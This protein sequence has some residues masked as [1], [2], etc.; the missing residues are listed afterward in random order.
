[1]QL[2]KKSVLIFLLMFLT[3]CITDFKP[4]EPENYIDPKIV[5]D[6][7][8]IYNVEFQGHPNF[9]IS[10][11]RITN[12][13]YMYK[14]GVV[15]KTGNL[16]RFSD[17]NYSS[18]VKNTRNR[19]ME[20][21]LPQNGMEREHTYFQKYDVNESSLTFFH[22][23]GGLTVY[24]KS[25]I[26]EKVTNPVISEFFS[27]VDSDTFINASIWNYPS[28]YSGHITYNVD[29]LIYKIYARSNNN[30]LLELV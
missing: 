22:N 23:G 9:S 17:T 10:G 26:G 7:Y 12:E 6:W 19:E 29:S 4:A 20:I 24:E 15:I 3:N 27:I 28:A 13:G 2:I 11:F 8:K 25:K 16:E 21:F 18:I 5:G 1:M 30:R 14:L